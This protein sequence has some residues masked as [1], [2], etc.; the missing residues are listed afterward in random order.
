MIP[1]TK[2]VGTLGIST[3]KSMRFK[4]VIPLAL[5][6]A[7]VIALSRL[8]ADTIKLKD[9]TEIT[10]TVIEQTDSYWVKT[11]DGQTRT[12]SK[13][14]VD[15]VVKGNPTDAS[16]TP[17]SNANTPDS[18]S[19]GTG[20]SL[21]LQQVKE[22][23]DRCEQPI[24]AVTLWQTFLDGNPPAEDAAIAKTELAHWQ[25]LEHQNAEKI[26][27]KWIGGAE[28]QKLLDHV[29]DLIEEADKDFES[30][31]E[32]AAI[33]KLQ[34]A[35][36]LYPK[37]FAANFTL[38]YFL[39]QRH[40]LDDAL[41][42]LQ[43]AQSLRPNNAEVLTNLAIAQNFKRQFQDSVLS[44]Y[45]AA[46][47]KDT[48]EIVQN[49]VNAISY[50]PPGM[51][52]N[53]QT[54]RP[55]MEAAHE[56]AA[57]YGISGP[58][59]EWTYVP[60]P[61]EANES[62]AG[63]KTGLLGNGS[64]FIISSDGFIITNRHVAKAGGLLAVRLS[65][66]TEHKAKVIYIDDDQDLA[67]LKIDNPK[68]LPFVTFTDEQEPVPGAQCTALG[69]PLGNFLSYSLQITPGSVSSVIDSDSANVV[70][71]CKVNPGNSGGP[72]VDKYGR[73]MGIITQKTFSGTYI[74]SYGKAIAAGRVHKFLDKCRE[75]FPDVPAATVSADHGAEMET[76]AI[77]KQISPATVLVVILRD[78]SVKP[79]AGSGA[80]GASGG[81]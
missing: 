67:L 58:A 9:G 4:W 46:Q 30:H 7:G 22:K 3:G 66:E 56:L 32:L 31:Q 13:D 69:Y 25:D 11:P 50:A 6:L 36:K 12:I 59:A 33:D 43:T 23:A 8:R 47:A 52:E 15:S 71:T 10:G 51:R 74:E 68:P 37:N 29:H 55:A 78:D 64:G 44:A 20:G 81:N 53:N 38:G 54:I 19:Q 65:D 48:R 28:R 39:L 80:S 77:Y 79:D 57:K 62:E 18:D 45:K 27:G 75:K 42:A 21:A 61:R 76:E 24:E 2:G 73:V 5:M 34:E 17:Q 40:H 26:N 16:G 63:P 72:L 49:L 14:D 70:V 60:L 1:P 41:A 35:V